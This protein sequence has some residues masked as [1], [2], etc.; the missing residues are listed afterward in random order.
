MVATTTSKGSKKNRKKSARASENGAHE[1]ENG[2]ANDET[3]GDGKSSSS[4]SSSSGEN[5]NSKPEPRKRK[6]RFVIC[7]VKKVKIK[8]K[9][10]PQIHW[11]PI[12]ETPPKLANTTEAMRWV[13][14]NGEALQG[15]NFV[16][17]Q[18]REKGFV[19]ARVITKVRTGVSS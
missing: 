6:A 9:D 4:G 13:K 8:G 1:G 14:D 2:A 7:V 11:V 3:E 15:Q 12:A 10:E 18:I 5:G 19:E 17:A 16:I